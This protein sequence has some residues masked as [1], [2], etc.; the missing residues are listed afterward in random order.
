M[1]RRIDGEVAK[2]SFDVTVAVLALALLAPLLVLLAVV[3]WLDSGG[4]VLFTQLR[5]GRGGRLFP[6]YKFRTMVVGASKMAANISP[7]GDARI[8]RVGALLRASFL[9]ELPQLLNVLKG[10]MSIVGPRPETPEYVA[11]YTPEERRVLSVRPGI[12][13]PSTIAYWN[14][15]EI[16]AACPDPTAYYAQHL[17]H[18]RA[19]LDLASLEVKRPVRHDLA[20][21]VQLARTLLTRPGRALPADEGAPRDA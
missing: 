15:P 1:T 16:L 17:V 7:H 13:G 6:I 4:P 14:E 21:L 2:R 3:V 5:V 18:E 8:T 10:D 12:A 9:D 11:L 20:L 19:R